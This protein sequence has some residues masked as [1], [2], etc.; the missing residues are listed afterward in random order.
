MAQIAR[1][2]MAEQ[3]LQG[4]QLG[5]QEGVYDGVQWSMESSLHDQ[6]QGIGLYHLTLTLR[7]GNREERFT[8]LRLR[9]SAQV[10]TR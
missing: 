7:Q 9:R 2:L 4:V 1:T 3:W 6:R 5:R 8:S 10:E